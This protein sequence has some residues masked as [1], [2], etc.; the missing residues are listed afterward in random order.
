VGSIETEK[1]TDLMIV[2]GEAARDIQGIE[3]VEMVFKDEIGYDSR[4]LIESV[5]GQVGIR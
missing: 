4:K 1:Q 3:S 2:K 5:K